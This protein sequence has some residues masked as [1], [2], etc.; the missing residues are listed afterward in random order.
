MSTLEKVIYLA[1]YMEP[2][3]SFCDL[4]ELRHLAEE[5]LDKALLLAFTMAVEQLEREKTLVHPNS[6]C[7]RDYLKGMLL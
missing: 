3:R 2:S 5:N 6:V 7:A 4:S 1:D